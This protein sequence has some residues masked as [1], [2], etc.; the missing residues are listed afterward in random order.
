MLRGRQAA[1][2]TH[3]PHPPRSLQFG[4]HFEFDCKDCVCLEGGS[5]IVCQPKQCSQEPPARCEEDGTYLVTEVNPAD[6]CCNVTFCSK[7]GQG[8]RGPCPRPGPFPLLRAGGPW[9][10]APEAGAGGVG[11]GGWAVRPGQELRP[12]PERGV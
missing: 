3:L 6:V 10:R 5:G 12:G 7:A 9:A 1:D 8:G 2:S 11:W 4:E